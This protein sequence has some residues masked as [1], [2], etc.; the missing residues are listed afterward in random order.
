[1]ERDEEMVGKARWK[2]EGEE[3]KKMWGKVGG[4]EMG[5]EDAEA[6]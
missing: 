1:M 4:R 3:G 6:V 5:A 2:E